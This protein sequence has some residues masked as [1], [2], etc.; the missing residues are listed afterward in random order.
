[1]AGS[2]VDLTPP[3][4]VVSYRNG[5]GGATGAAPGT[6]GEVAAV[7]GTGPAGQ[8]GAAGITQPP[9]GTG[10][11]GND[12]G[13]RDVALGNGGVGAGGATVGDDTA[14]TGGTS[15]A[16]GTEPDAPTGGGG[17]AIDA[18]V[19]AG[20]VGSTDGPG[21][22]GQ[23]GS[24]GASSTA[25]ITGAG[26]ITG[27]G[28]TTTGSGGTTIGSGGTTTGSGGATTGSGGSTAV[29]TAYNC[30]SPLVPQ[31]GVVTD[32]TDWNSTTNRWGS[33][34]TLIGDIFYYSGG[35]ASITGKVGG[36]PIGLNLS[37]SVPTNGGYGGGGLNFFSCVTTASFTKISFDVSGSASNCNIELQLQTY[38]QRPMEQAPPGACKGDAG[39]NSCYKFPAKSQVVT[40]PA[41]N[42]SVTL[43][44]ITNWTAAAGA[45]IVGVQW[46]F[47][48][49][50]SNTCTPNVTFTNVKFQ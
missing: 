7:G 2:C 43:S 12:A 20:G 29:P 40:A 23:T 30:T 38:D 32:S 44:G 11:M 24:G 39:A 15:G 50:G 13:P 4:E 8:G 45:Q 33:G 47:T 35:G 41:T 10:G 3:P 46:Q 36:S 25:G 31:N 17:E 27:K 37:G 5:K 22:G 49:S 9:Q 21:K 16:G 42:V 34:S 18:P 1:M 26:G 19:G 14:D 28:G 48:T 6:G